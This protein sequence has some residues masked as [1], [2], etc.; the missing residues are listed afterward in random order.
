MARSKVYD[1]N[2]DQSVTINNLFGV[3]NDD[4]VTASG[5]G[6]FDNKNV[7]TNKTITVAYQLSGDDAANY[8]LDG[9]TATGD[10]TAKAIDLHC[11]C[12]NKVTMATPLQQ[13]Q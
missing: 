11:G 3:I 4:D 5:S 1:G 13:P 2:L 7:G 10:I 6:N 9:F 12:S 8:S